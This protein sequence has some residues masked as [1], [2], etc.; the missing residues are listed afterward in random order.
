MPIEQYFFEKSGPTKFPMLQPCVK[1]R[2]KTFFLSELRLLYPM[3]GMKCTFF[4]SKILLTSENLVIFWWLASSE[5]EYLSS[6]TTP[7]IL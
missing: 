5:P 3:H 6:T 4:V 7:R 1:I 2:L